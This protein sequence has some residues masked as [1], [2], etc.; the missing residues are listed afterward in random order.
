MKKHAIDYVIGRMTTIDKFITCMMLANK[1]CFW[2]R[3]PRFY[4]SEETI[5][6]MCPPKVRRFFTLENLKRLGVVY[7]VPKE[8]HPVALQGFGISVAKRLYE[9]GEARKVYELYGAEY[10][11]L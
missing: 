9:T 5:R 2:G 11:P 10:V 6:R 1:I 3:V 7:A 8:G 4:K